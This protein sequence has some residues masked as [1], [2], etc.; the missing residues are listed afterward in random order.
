VRD[1]WRLGCKRDALR[2]LAEIAVSASIDAD[3]M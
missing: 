1:L 2:V 3:V